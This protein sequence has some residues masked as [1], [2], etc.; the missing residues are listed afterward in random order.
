MLV[1]YGLPIRLGA[2]VVVLLIHAAGVGAQTPPGEDKNSL[3]VRVHGF[4]LGNF[5]AR[6][7]GT[8][9][10]GGEGRRFL[11]ADER[12]RLEIAKDQTHANLSFLFKGDL[13]HDAV[14]NKFDGVVR[15]AY[16]DYSRA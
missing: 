13:F 16:A 9:P 12:L 7:S 5:T 10:P 15:E 1:N 6:T 11:W 14:A 4:L 8:H 3:P 2:L